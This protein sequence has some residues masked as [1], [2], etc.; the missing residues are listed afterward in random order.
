[1]SETEPIKSSE[2]GAKVSDPIEDKLYAAYLYKR[3]LRVS[4]NLKHVNAETEL[5]KSDTYSMFKNGL[6]EEKNKLHAALSAGCIDE[7]LLREEIGYLTDHIDA[8]EHEAPW[9]S[10]ANLTTAKKDLQLL[11]A[12]LQKHLKNKQVDKS[13]V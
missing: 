8:M 9:A 12:I 7:F 13:N 5:E 11:N 1:M 10:P 3:L 2:V 4:S 6:I